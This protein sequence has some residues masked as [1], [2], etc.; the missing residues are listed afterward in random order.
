MIICRVV[1]TTVAT[2]KDPNLQGTKLLIVAETDPHGQPLPA[3]T[4]IVADAVGAG[5]GDLVLVATGSAANNTP[6]TSKAPVDAVAIAIVDTVF[7][8]GAIMYQPEQARS[9]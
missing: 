3:Q 6:Q 4:L 1:G 7:G 9:S 5:R 2:R 8:S